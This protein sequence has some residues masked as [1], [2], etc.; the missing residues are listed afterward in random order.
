[1]ELAL[2]RQDTSRRIQQAYDLLKSEKY[3]EVLQ[4]LAN[5]A[6]EGLSDHDKDL[7][8]YLRGVASSKLAQW[9]AAVKAFGGMGQ[10]N[11]EGLDAL[12]GLALIRSG[13]EAAGVSMLSNFPAASRGDEVNRVLGHIHA[14]RGEYEKAAGY[15]SAIRSPSREDLEAQLTARKALGLE[16]HRRGEYALAV[17]ELQVARQILEAQL[18][19]K[20]VDV[21]LRLGDSYY[22][23]ND[24]EKAKKTFR[25]LSETDLTDAERQQARDLFL[26]RGQISL[27]EK[28]PDVAYR[29]FCEF[30]RLGGQMPPDLAQVQGQL[31][32]TYAD[33]LPVDKVQYWNYASTSKD[34]NFSLVVRGQSRGE[35]IIERREAGN[36][37]EEIWTREG[38][39]LT[40]K[41]G[42][43]IIKLPLNLNPAAETLPFVVYTSQGQECTSEIVAVGQTVELPGGR[44]FT[45]CLKV[46]VRR[47]SSV[48]EGKVHSTR[49]VYYFAPNV[50]EVKQEVY[51]D[52]A[53]V[54]EIIL[55]D[56]ALKV[57]LLER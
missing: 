18:L 7:Y 16:H 37:S 21:Y 25:D 15:L 34:Y 51:R 31:V 55:S 10:R 9:T 17:E 22:R 8:Y 49:N 26:L 4:S 3:Q 54:S 33:F 57:A 13:Q 46:R 12:H 5:T 29:D 48:S 24:L 41:I 42:E 39:Y 43:T 32:A 1:V 23:Q 36:T 2:S 40:R 11:F 50:G 53:K 38:I 52:D 6:V 14:G 27:R 45:D 30:V 20:D 56:Y 44:K 19:R 35:Y 47:T 28:R